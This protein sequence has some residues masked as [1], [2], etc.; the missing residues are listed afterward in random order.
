VGGLWTSK[1]EWKKIGRWETW[2][3]AVKDT[4]KG[5]GKMFIV[6]VFTVIILITL[7]NMGIF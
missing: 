6:K 4:G 5:I 1:E 3:P 7:V 2:R